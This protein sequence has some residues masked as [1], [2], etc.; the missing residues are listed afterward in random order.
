M[1]EETEF[2]IAVLHVLKRLLAE[3]V[4]EQLE[5]MLINQVPQQLMLE[6]AEL[7]LQIQ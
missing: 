1:L 3:V 5:Q 7:E 6:Q 2:G 4:V